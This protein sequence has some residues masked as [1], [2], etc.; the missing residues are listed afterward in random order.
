MV[1]RDERRIVCRE[2]RADAFDTFGAPHLSGERADK[3]AK[4]RCLDGVAPRADNHDIGDSRARSGGE[5]GL[6]KV[7]GA[8]RLWVVG[9]LAFSRESPAQERSDG[10]ERDQDAGDPG[11]DRPPW[12]SSARERKSLKP[13]GLHDLPLCIFG[14]SPGR[15]S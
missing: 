10:D 15:S 13:R 14:R 9:W 2:V 11:A 3:G 5:C 1:L 8:L 6:A 12:M 4:A 7:L